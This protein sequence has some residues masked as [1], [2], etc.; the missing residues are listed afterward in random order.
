VATRKRRAL[1]PSGLVGAWYDLKAEVDKVTGR[2]AGMVSAAE[3]LRERLGSE[4]GIAVPSLIV[5]VGAEGRII[6]EDA[7]AAAGSQLPMGEEPAAP[8][9]TPANT[10]RP[11]RQG[12]IAGSEEGAPA[13]DTVTQIRSDAAMS[14]A[15]PKDFAASIAATF[16]GIQRGLGG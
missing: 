3:K 8:G 10:Y 6:M 13:D 12:P 14:G 15:D 7:P 1:G 9:T 16:S 4:Y 2:L 5:M 11:P